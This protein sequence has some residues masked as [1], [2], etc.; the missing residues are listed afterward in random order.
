[1]RLHR[2]AEPRE[3]DHDDTSCRAHAPAR[4]RWR[5]NGNR[6]NEIASRAPENCRRPTAEAATTG[7]SSGATWPK[8]E[9]SV[10]PLRIFRASIILCLHSAYVTAALACRASINAIL[11]D[12]V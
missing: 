6:G 7:S 11:R 3:V 9:A 5:L 10:T 12:F 8:R 1:M 2:L 4:P